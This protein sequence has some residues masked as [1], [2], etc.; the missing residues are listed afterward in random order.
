M[1]AMTDPTTCS[2]SPVSPGANARKTHTPGTTS[3]SRSICGDPRR[4]RPRAGRGRRPQRIDDVVA[5]GVGQLVVGADGGDQA[6]QEL[7]L[8]THR[9]LGHGVEERAQDLERTAVELEGVLLLASNPAPR[10]SA[11]AC[12]ATGDRAWRG[13]PRPL[14][15]VLHRALVEADLLEQLAGGGEDRVGALGRQG[16]TTT[17]RWSVRRRRGICHTRTL[18]RSPPPGG[19]PSGTAV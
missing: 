7:A 1:R 9:G 12:S 19:R 10:S 4:A 8:L 5:Q 11:R 16:S 6:G 13:P 18:R 14:G 3:T 2:E 17:N 15:D